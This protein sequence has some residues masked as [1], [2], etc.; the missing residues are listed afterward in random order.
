MDLRICGIV[1]LYNPEQWVLDNIRS[2]LF[3][4]EKLFVMD[5]SVDADRHLVD[6]IKSLNKEICYFHNNQNDGIA[7]AV[8]RAAV[9]AND[10]GFSHALIMDQDSS[11]DRSEITNYLDRV[12]VDVE[13]NKNIVL[14]GASMSESREVSDTLNCPV[15]TSGSL[16]DIKVFIEIGMYNERLFIDEVD[17]EFS[18]RVLNSG[19][20][21][22][23]YHDVHI[24]HKLGEEISV[25]RESFRLYPPFRYYYF[26]RN[27]LYL[28]KYY[29]S[30][31]F[32]FV[33]NRRRQLGLKIITFLKY[34]KNRVRCLYYVVLGFFH[35]KIGKWGKGISF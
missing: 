1:T 7:L 35:A 5:N 30:R 33:K 15:M 17:H 14:F 18:L 13:N 6:Q 23:R 28:K 2:Y 19:F 4:T 32:D 21:I 16:I 24:H 12:A 20:L 31:N 10:H 34:H 22:K 11:F 8:N 26:T 27:Y 3:S 9:I 29:S 25:G